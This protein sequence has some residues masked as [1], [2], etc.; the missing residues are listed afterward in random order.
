MAKPIIVSLNGTESA[1]D[2]AKV[3]RKRLYGERRRV[4]LDADGE[5][6][7]KSALTADGQYLLQSGMTAQGYFDEEGRWLQKSQLVGI[8]SDG[9]PL[10]IQPSTLGLAQALEPTPPGTILEHTIEAVYGLDPLT[11]DGALMTRLEAGEVF[12]FG[13]NYSAD[14]HQESAFLLKST[15]GVFCLVGVPFTVSWSEPG[16]VA[17]IAADEETSDD[18]DFEMF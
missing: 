8:G 12:K 3:E 17:D 5:P 1:F 13:F 16:K 18:L 14:Y 7:L 10:Q 11:V 15:E 6:C 2:H 9:E 4:P